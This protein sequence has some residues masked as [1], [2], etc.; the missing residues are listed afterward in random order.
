MLIE[1]FQCPKLVSRTKGKL[2]R[3]YNW[4]FLKPLPSSTPKDMVY[5]DLADKGNNFAVNMACI[6]LTG[7][8]NPILLEFCQHYFLY[9][10]VFP[11]P[12]AMI[13]T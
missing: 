10:E 4:N 1:L 6:R 9:N 2:S 3:C 5:A 13:G 8:P 7:C 12:T 11:Q